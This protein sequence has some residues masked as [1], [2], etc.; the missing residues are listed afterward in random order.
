ML[1]EVR[2]YLR[3]TWNDEDAV[4][5]SMIA[6]GKSTINNLVGAN[7]DYTRGGLAKTLLLN[8]CRYDYNNAIE[9][10][11]ENFQSEILRLQL[12]VG[13]DLLAALSDLSVEGVT[14]SPEFNSLVTEYTAST[15]DD[16]NVISVTPISDSATV[17]IDV[18]G[19]VI[20]NGS[21]VTWATGDNTVKITVT[22]GNETKIYTVTV[23]KS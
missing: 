11:E 17:E 10:F 22:D 7:L 20:D 13:T 14:L 1:D 21:A 3:I 15:T 6:R 19:I 4:L 8:Y 9:Y 18:D 12:K 2:S 5:Q 16:S 23:T